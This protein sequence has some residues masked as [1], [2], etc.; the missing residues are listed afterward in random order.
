MSE[1]PFLP[2]NQYLDSRRLSARASL[3]QRFSTSEIDWNSW[4]FSLIAPTSSSVILETGCGPGYL[5]QQPSS[6]LPLG[7]KVC[8]T[9]LSPGMLAEAR[10]VLRSQRQFSFCTCD[11]A[12]MPFPDST[13]DAVIA[14]HML[15]HVQDLPAALEGIWRVLRPG[16]CLYAATNG[17]DHLREIHAWQRT[18]QSAGTDDSWRTSTEGFNLE[19]GEGVLRNWF[20]QIELH[21]YPD[22]LYVTEVEPILAYIDSYLEAGLDPLARNQ[23]AG[24]LGKLLEAQGGIR[25]TKQSGLFVAVKR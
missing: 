18:F 21:I 17:Q 24:L 3:H 14:N 6:V 25:I 13:F 19:N 2:R 5:W 8:L 15:Y 7:S 23:L 1:L 9:D 11:A 12:R 4:V 16:S 22:Q 20:P 10:D